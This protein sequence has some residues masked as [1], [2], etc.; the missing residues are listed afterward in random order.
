MLWKGLVVVGCLT[1]GACAQLTPERQAALEAYCE[2]HAAGTRGALSAEQMDALG[3]IDLSA[4]LAG[5]AYP[6]YV[7]EAAK[8]RR[9]D[10][11]RR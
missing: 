3:M 8:E 1:L 5:P 11:L 6:S 10:A 2:F 4:D 7:S 9:V